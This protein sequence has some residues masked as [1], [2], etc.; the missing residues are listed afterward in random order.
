MISALHTQLSLY[1][2]SSITVPGG[3]YIADHFIL[4]SNPCDGRRDNGSWEIMDTSSNGK[5]LILLFCCPNAGDGFEDK[6]HMR[7]GAE[8]MNARDKRNA[9]RLLRLKRDVCRRAGCDRGKVRCKPVSGLPKT[10]HAPR[11]AGR[12]V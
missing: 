2:V 8:K 4:G 3:R 7:K 9:V 11:R 1:E 5:L 6:Y 10:M 12:R